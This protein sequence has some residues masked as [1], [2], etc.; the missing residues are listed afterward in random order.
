MTLGY[1]IANVIARPCIRHVHWPG[2]GRFLWGP[3]ILERNAVTLGTLIG[4]E[5]AM[6]FAPTLF[7]CVNCPGFRH[8]RIGGLRSRRSCLIWVWPSGWRAWSALSCW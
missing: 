1:L 2:A 3:V 7:L 5:I 6:T 8:H 4:A